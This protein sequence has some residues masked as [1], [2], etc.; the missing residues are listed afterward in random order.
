MRLFAALLIALAIAMAV[1]CWA[2]PTTAPASQVKKLIPPT[3]FPQS[4]GVSVHGF[5]AGPGELDQFAASGARLLRIDAYWEWVESE[6]GKYDFSQY[7]DLA[8]RAS[9]R[10]VRVLLIILGGNKLYGGQ[11][12]E[13]PKTAEGRAAFARMAAE[14]A[15]TMKG[16]PIVFEL[17][18][19][20]DGTDGPT[21]SEYY[22]WAK[23]TV[24]AMRAVDSNVVIAGPS[25]HHYALGWIEQVFALGYLDLVDAV[26]VHLYLGHSP[27]DGWRPPEENIGCIDRLRGLITQYGKGRDIPACNSEV[28]YNRL[29]PGSTN[30][31]FAIST[32]DQARYAAR[33]FLLSA[34]WDLRFH[35]NYCWWLDAPS[36]RDTTDFGMV[37]EAGMPMPVY[38]AMKAMGEQLNGGRFSRRIN[39]GVDDDYALEFTTPKGKVVACWTGNK[40]AVLGKIPVGNAKRVRVV[41]MS[42]T[43]SYELIPENGFVSIRLVGAP[44]YL[45]L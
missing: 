1:P 10:N 31:S 13:Y 40:D 42:G 39:L 12:G 38:Y 2:A 6:K 8:Q 21:P 23:D 9:K 29:I 18:N 36:I 5:I 19:E 15:R 25:A 24:E 27:K 44:V 34:L 17:G 14:L 45:R 33:G 22:A 43:R 16:K 35:V 11:F 37:T 41:D 32:E 30:R 20:P 4:I 28:G 3:G 26:T 7:V